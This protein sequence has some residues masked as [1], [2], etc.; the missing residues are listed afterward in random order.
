MAL[1]YF[2]FFT[3]DS[4]RTSTL[5]A[6]QSTYLDTLLICKNNFNHLDLLPS[7]LSQGGWEEVP[8]D[9]K[10]KFL[11]LEKHVFR[12]K[13]NE[14]EYKIEF[15]NYPAVNKCSIQIRNM[16]NIPKSFTRDILMEFTPLDD[17]GY[18]CRQDDS[19]VPTK[20]A[21]WKFKDDSYIRYFNL[22]NTKTMLF[23]LSVDIERSK[24]KDYKFFSICKMGYL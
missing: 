20:Y 18:S 8:P 12:K 7:I 10:Y 21:E 19:D 9:A 14:E 22:L 13:Q 4:Q 5:H 3:R 24:T 16:K 15:G 2:P 17:L 1:L 6:E 11:E 23:T